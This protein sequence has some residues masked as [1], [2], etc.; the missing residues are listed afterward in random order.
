MTQIGHG[1][2]LPTGLFYIASVESLAQ[3]AC[4]YKYDCVKRPPMTVLASSD[5]SHVL[6]CFDARWSPR[7][8]TQHVGKAV[9]DTAQLA[10]RRGGQIGPRQHHRRP[11][12]RTIPI[13]DV[14]QPRRIPDSFLSVAV[15]EIGDLIA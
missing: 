8:R 6:T 14:V 2:L 3:E 5:P 10:A 15:H 9:A 4:F 12:R 1:R 11:R 13:P 7:D